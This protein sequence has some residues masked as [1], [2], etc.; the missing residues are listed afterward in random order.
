MI[1][2][3]WPMAKL[4][5]KR[6]FLSPW[7]KVPCLGSPRSLGSPSSA[8]EIS[9]ISVS[10]SCSSVDAAVVEGLPAAVN[11]PDACVLSAPCGGTIKSN[12][13]ATFSEVRAR[14]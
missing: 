6:M 12:S 13:L 5:S 3:G 7:F 9:V 2:G 10:R 4:P 8:N 1:G 11:G 14:W